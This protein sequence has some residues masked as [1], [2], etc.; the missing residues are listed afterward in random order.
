MGAVG[1]VE[2]KRGSTDETLKIT[3]KAGVAGI[4]AAKNDAGRRI[5]KRDQA[6]AMQIAGHLVDDA[7]CGGAERLEPM[8]M[9]LAMA[10]DVLACPVGGR[11]GCFGAGECGFDLRNRLEFSGTENLRMARGDLL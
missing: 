7:H 10:S 8:E 2:G 1:Q 3:G 4:A 6:E 9:V 11:N 5:Q